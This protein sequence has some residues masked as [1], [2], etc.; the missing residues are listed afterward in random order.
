MPRLADSNAHQLSEDSELQQQ[1][2]P[3]KQSNPTPR[4]V[5]SC[6]TIQ[7]LGIRTTTIQERRERLVLAARR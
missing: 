5:G 3:L 1:T 4:M 7:H 2:K 6:T